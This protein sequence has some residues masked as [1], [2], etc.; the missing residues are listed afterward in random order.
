MIASSVRH[1]PQKS[2][3]A[4][5]NH[6]ALTL[7]EKVPMG[8]CCGGGVAAALVVTVTVIAATFFHM[9]SRKKSYRFPA[10]MIHDTGST[11][12]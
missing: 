3:R 6:R 5:G 7:I 9:I 2:T 12:R 10:A 1:Q 11:V 4:A 8:I